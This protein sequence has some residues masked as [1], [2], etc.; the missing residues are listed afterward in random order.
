M[1]FYRNITLIKDYMHI[2]FHGLILYISLDINSLI[3]NFYRNSKI[4]IKNILGNM[5]IMPENN[6]NLVLKPI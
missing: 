5:L 3:A 4:K 1:K 2:K 6:P